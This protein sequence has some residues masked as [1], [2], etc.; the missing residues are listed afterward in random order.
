[1]SKK[2]PPNWKNFDFWVLVSAVIGLGIAIAVFLSLRKFL[3]E[4]DSG[5][6]DIITA[7][8]TALGG[9]TIGGVAVMQYRKHKWAE[10]QAKLDEDSRTGE[11]LSQAIEHLGDKENLHIRLG[12][13]YEFK[14]LVEDSARN[15]ENIM[16]IITA[17]IKS[18]PAEKEQMTP[19]DIEA[20]A[21]VLSQLARE[22]IELTAEKAR[23]QFSR[24]Q[25]V[26]YIAWRLRRREMRKKTLKKLSSKTKKELRQSKKALL[27]LDKYM[28]KKTSSECLRVVLPE[29]VFIATKEISKL[30]I[31][32]PFPWSKLKANQVCFRSK[33][34][35][36]GIVLRNADLSFAQ[37]NEVDFENAD[38]ENIEFMG[39]YLKGTSFKGANMKTEY[40]SAND[41]ESADFTNARLEGVTFLGGS[42]DGVDFENSHLE[43]ADVRYVTF[44]NSK[45]LNT[46]FID[47]KTLFA[48]GIR[49]KYF[50][51]EEPEHCESELSPISR[52][53]YQ[54]QQTET[55]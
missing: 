38:L 20:A 2:K 22:I 30:D 17:Y 42:L 52:V 54:K 34:S 26:R 40:L 41:L 27:H 45:N 10:Y 35:G 48:S 51:V 11:R 12:A 19:Q 50:G 47:D 29:L 25:I 1:M 33:N 18:Y 13:I 43:G 8:A 7:T 55:V 24:K 31:E 9:L 4:A 28:S 21:R 46:A 5:T 44:E 36:S 37:L 53:Q 15:K 32:N 16:Q 14:N 3:F 49:F 39:A 6:G 23:K